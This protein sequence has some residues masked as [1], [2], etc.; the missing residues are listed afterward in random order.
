M[1]KKFS[2]TK[3]RVDSKWIYDTFTGPLNI[4]ACVNGKEVLF[5]FM[6]AWGDNIMHLG[7][8]CNE[9]LFE[10]ESPEYFFDKYKRV[11]ISDGGGH[12]HFALNIYSSILK[13]SPKENQKDFQFTGRY[14]STQPAK[15]EFKRRMIEM[16][17]NNE[18][19]EDFL[20]E[21]A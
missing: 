7:I 17:N 5:Q 8:D 6:P 16:Y 15:E 21:V 3:V 4:R 12:K 20:N 10:K 11:K 14:Y 1:A 9:A 19:T 18:F 13:R 2:V